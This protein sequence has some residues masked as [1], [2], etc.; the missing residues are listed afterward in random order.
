MKKKVV[1]CMAVLGLGLLALAGCG[2]KEAS[3]DAKELNWDL[4]WQSF[5]P[6]N[7]PVSEGCCLPS[8]VP[9]P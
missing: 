2:K 1:V 8:P 6:L 9:L 7:P 5:C 3:A 4:M